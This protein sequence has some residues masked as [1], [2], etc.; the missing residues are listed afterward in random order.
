MAAAS[1]CSK[2]GQSLPRRTGTGRSFST[3]TSTGQA[4]D[5]AEMVTLRTGTCRVSPCTHVIG[6][7]DFV[8]PQ[9]ARTQGCIRL[10]ALPES[11]RAGNG[12]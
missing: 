12:R 3:P 10:T 7:E 5:A 2:P 1:T 4:P 6:K 11:S 9:G 8:S